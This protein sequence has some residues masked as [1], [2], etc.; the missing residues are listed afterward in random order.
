MN[1]EI[2]VMI[3]AIGSDKSAQSV[4]EIVVPEFSPSSAIA[5]GAR[6]L[7]NRVAVPPMVLPH[8]RL[9]YSDLP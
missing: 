1:N 3:A 6:P 4:N 5:R 2:N 7:P 9:K 8:A